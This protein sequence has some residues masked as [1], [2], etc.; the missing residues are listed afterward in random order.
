MKNWEFWEVYFYLVKN[1]H[2]TFIYFCAHSCAKSIIKGK[3]YLSDFSG[4]LLIFKAFLHL[5]KSSCEQLTFVLY[6]NILFPATNK[7]F[8][9]NIWTRDTPLRW[10]L[11]QTHVSSSYHTW[12]YLRTC[13]ISAECAIIYESRQCDIISIPWIN[14]KILLTNRRQR[15]LAKCL[16]FY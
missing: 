2:L 14:L 8:R 10:R 7:Y 11:F 6:D 12:N 4:R 9:W 15:L 16:R 13:W 1:P 5:F 3:K